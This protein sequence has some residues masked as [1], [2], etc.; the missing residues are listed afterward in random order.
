MTIV[1]VVQHDLA[2][3]IVFELFESEGE[4]RFVPDDPEN[5]DRP[6]IA[7]WVAGGNTIESA[8]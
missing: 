4:R 7:A 5:A 1:R 6:R 8:P 3:A 2:G